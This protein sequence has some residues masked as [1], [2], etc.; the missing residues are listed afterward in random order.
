MSEETETRKCPYCNGVMAKKVDAHGHPYF[1][2]I[3]TMT[4]RATDTNISE[5]KLG[6]TALADP[7]DRGVNA[8]GGKSNKKAGTPRAARRKK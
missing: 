8:M 4:C 2:C 5:K 7:E 6:T 1:Q 3:N